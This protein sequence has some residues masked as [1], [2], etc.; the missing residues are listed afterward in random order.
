M[1]SDLPKPPGADA[2][3]E[4]DVAERTLNSLASQIAVLDRDGKIVWVNEAWRRF[5]MDNGCLRG[6]AYLT[7]NYLSVC[8]QAGPIE[9]LAAEAA[10]GVRGVLSGDLPSF[11]LEYP[12]HSPDEERWFLMYVTPM[13]GGGAVVSH[14]NI[15]ARKWKEMAVL[16]MLGR[17]DGRRTKGGWG[18]RAKRVAGEAR[19]AMVAEYRAILLDSLESRVIRTAKPISARLALLAAE[20]GSLRATPRDVMDIHLSTVRGFP[21]EN[22]GRSVAVMEEGRFILIELLGLLAAYYRAKS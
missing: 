15:T 6:D 16:E 4:Q 17:E 20:L 12:C 8:A 22:S 13:D 9:P 19:S 11:T 1:L 18:A 5:G 7:D 21:R 10:E 2:E 14:V 3:I